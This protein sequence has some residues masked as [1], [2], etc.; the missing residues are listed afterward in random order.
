M[1]KAKNEEAS[2]PKT[3]GAAPYTSATGS[4]TDVPRKRT[5]KRRMAG[6]ALV[7]SSPRNATRSRGSMSASAVSTPR[8]TRSFTFRPRRTR[9]RVSGAAT[10]SRGTVVIARNVFVVCHDSVTG[11]Q[12]KHPPPANNAVRGGGS[13]VGGV[14]ELPSSRLPYHR[15]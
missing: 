5:P 8:Y 4:H 2:V 15:R 6:Q 7:P 11:G 1:N 13:R 12:K 10:G 9:Q 3:I 14:T